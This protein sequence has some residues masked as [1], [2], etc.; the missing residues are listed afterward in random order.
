MS[1][2]WQLFS[3]QEKKPNEPGQQLDLQHFAWLL[4]HEPRGD[5]PELVI[6]E[7]KSTDEDGVLVPRI[8]TA[9]RSAYNDFRP[10]TSV[11]DAAFFDLKSDIH[12]ALMSPDEAEVARVLGDPG[13]TNFFWGFD[14]IAKAP[15]GEVEPH[16]L[17]IRR[18]NS[19][20]DWR[21]LYSIWL[22]DALQSLAE[23]IGARR[24]VYPEMLPQ[25]IGARY[26]TSLG[27]DQIL[28]DID[29]ALGVQLIFPNPFPG[30]PG[31][32]TKKGVV[33]FRSLQA[34]YQAWRIAQ[35]SAD[36]PGFSVMEIGAGLGRTA[37]FA[38]AFGITNYTI[39]DIPLTNAAQASFLG[40]TLGPSQLCLYGESSS[41]PLR[42]LPPIAINSLNERFDLIVNVDS[43]TEMSPDIARGYWDF[44][45]K[46]TNAFLS[47]NHEVNELTVRSLYQN[48][49]NCRATRF[50]Y[51]MRRGY[52]EELIT[53]PRG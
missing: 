41:A 7:G 18:L 42:I 17:V 40:R 22:L 52:V 31:L 38:K 44:S 50:P 46:N 1:F 26:S 37:Y 24:M 11:W 14:A 13:E 53:W 6:S 12:E 28:D 45:L 3:A 33:G 21:K 16:E 35:I 4:N 19:S 8:S 5:I 48:T 39:I 32:A 43:L 36:Q 10:S 15:P 27:A 29:Q 30:E 49:P 2:L 23:A 9:Y 20:V 51:G 47:I 34:V 25:D